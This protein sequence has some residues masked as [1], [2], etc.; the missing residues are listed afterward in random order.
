MNRQRNSG[1]W[2]YLESVG[3][4]EKGTDEEIKIAKKA[5]RK[6]YL[7]QYKKQQR[8]RKPEF[9]VNFSHENREYSRVKQAAKRHKMPITGF[10]RSA[11]LGYIESRY[12]VPDALQVA[13]L[14]QSLADC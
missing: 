13:K 9:A 5:Y 1:M 4:L 12:V 6:I 14:E 3:I 7:S 11:V 10:I 2:E 8:S